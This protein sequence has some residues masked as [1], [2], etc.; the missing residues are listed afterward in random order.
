MPSSPR[1]KTSAAVQRVHGAV[2]LAL[3]IHTDPGEPLA[4][5]LSGGRDSV[6]LLAALVHMARARGHPLC[7]IHVHH[8]L[9]PNADDWGSFC[10]RLCADLH[11]ALITVPIKVPRAPSTSGEN[12]AR[13]LRYTALVEAAQE[14]GARHV[15]LGHHRDDQAETL[16]LQL[17]RGAGPHGL[18]GMAS[19][20]A[21]P[22]GI[23]WLRPLLDISRADIDA[24]VDEQKLHWID[25][26]SNASPLHLR[27]AVR[28]HVLPALARIHAEPGKTLARAARQQAEAARLADDL[29]AL[30]ARNAA[31]GA[32]LDRHALA[33]LP[34]HRARNL[35]RWFLREKLLPAPS[36]ARLAAMLDQLCHARDDAQ[37]R[38]CHAG[39]ELGIHRGRI[40]LHTPAPAAF[41]QQWNGEAVLAL[42]H[43]RLLFNRV[44]GGGADPGQLAR[45]PVCIR[46][47]RG[48]ERLQLAANRP[49]RALKTILQETGVPPW[50]RCGLPLLF[51]GDVLAAVARVGIDAAFRNATD[52]P[53]ITLDWQPHAL[54]AWRPVDRAADAGPD[55]VM[56][57]R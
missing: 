11:V 25:D 41:E 4:V 38:L 49:R 35:L 37:V 47:R 26:E 18:A 31:D 15:L 33:A 6:A 39:L 1:V 2:L 14:R 5:G 9:S 7:A 46:S 28:H 43:G 24:Y 36:E 22:C 16:L 30:D 34:P 42:P 12:E 55:R 17:L 29:A 10:A 13:N 48:G 8:G 50:Q 20:R 32:T 52:A 56:R 53:G 19:A 27:N 57:S 21:D 3:V 51:C 40:M 54:D 45:A 23:T 44:D